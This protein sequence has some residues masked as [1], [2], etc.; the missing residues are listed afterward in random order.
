MNTLHL[1]PL[2]Q[3]AFNELPKNLQEGWTWQE[4]KLTFEDSDVYR[5]LRL[6]IMKL[7]DSALLELRDRLRNVKSNE[8]TKTFLDEFD[9]RH[10]NNEDLTQIFYA[11]GPT[12]LNYIILSTLA[13]A[14]NDE[15]V[16][17]AANLSGMR[18]IILEAF[19]PAYAA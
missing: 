17:M 1:Y 3:A 14:K 12:P 5:D 9:L 18:H 7:H 13:L 2:E 4:E 11:M 19:I 8:E 6:S 16:E 15:D 10:V